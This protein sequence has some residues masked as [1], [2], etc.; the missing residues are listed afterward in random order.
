MSTLKELTK[1]KHIE[2]ESQPFIQALFKKSVNKYDYA[3]YLFQLHLIYYTL[4]SLGD[5]LELFK[6]IEEIKRAPSIRKDFIELIGSNHTKKIGLVKPSTSNYIR[7]INTLSY[8]EDSKKI[9]A[10]IYVR[11]MGDL[12]GGQSLKKLVPGS[13]KMF[14]FNNPLGLITSMRNRLSIDMADEANLAFQY[15]I[16][17]IKEF[18]GKYLDF[19]N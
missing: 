5:F 1:E 10:H 19:I 12:Y 14:D 4:E 16:N 7:Y 17:I 15:N 9:M 11:H 6:D 13:G 3:E 2:A 8:K 18:N